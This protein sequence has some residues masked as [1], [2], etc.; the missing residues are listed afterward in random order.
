MS[1]ATDS[2]RHLPVWAQHAA[3]TTYG[4]YWHWLRFGPGYGASVRAYRERERFTAEDWRRW[5]QARLTRLLANAVEHV[6]HYRTVWGSAEKQA[7]LAGRLESLP[8]LE[9]EPL[10]ANA[11]AFLR[12]DMRA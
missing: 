1:L 5:Q 10:R 6:P 3:V 9:K 8:L 2:Y 4:L 11:A 7:A 12:G